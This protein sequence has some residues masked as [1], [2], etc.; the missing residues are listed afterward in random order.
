MVGEDQVSPQKRK[1]KKKKHKHK[2][3]NKIIIT[4]VRKYKG[5]PENM[6]WDLQYHRTIYKLNICKSSSQN[7]SESSTQ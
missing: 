4:L 7:P 6:S 2:Q 3:T 1:R 5:L